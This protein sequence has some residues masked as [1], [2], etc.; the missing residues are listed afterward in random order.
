MK[1]NGKDDI[2]YIMAHK[3]CLKPPTSYGSREYLLLDIL[4]HLYFCD[5]SSVFDDGWIVQWLDNAQ[6]CIIYMEN[7]KVSK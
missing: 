3:K 5:L 1:V 4:Y 6:Y 2:P 7:R